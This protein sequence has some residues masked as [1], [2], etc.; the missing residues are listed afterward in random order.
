MLK[1]TTIILLMKTISV[2]LQGSEQLY[3]TVNKAI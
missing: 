1:N 2:S 3:T